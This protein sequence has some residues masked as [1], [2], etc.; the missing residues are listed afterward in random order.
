MTTDTV[1]DVAEIVPVHRDTDA[2][3][4]ALAAYDQL[5]GQLGRLAPEHW[6]AP[7]DCT[8]W[9]VAAI[10]GHL[11]GAARSN[12]STRE[13]LRQQLHGRRHASDHG[14]NALDACNALQVRDHAH[15]AP[16]ERV[17]QLRRL[18]P[19]AVAGRLRTPGLVRR[20]RV[21]LDQGG[22]TPPGSPDRLAMDR[23][24]DVVYTRDVWL[25]T[26]DVERATGVGVDRAVGPTRRLLE[27]VVAEW[28]ARHGRPFEL[29]LTGAGGGRFRQ[30]VGGP[31]IELDAVEFA[32]VLS[33]RA[34]G[35][36]LLAVRVVF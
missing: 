34:A 12:A 26:V 15:L 33:G 10:V 36:G 8:G 23:L 5:L 4:V 6:A 31:V 35:E 21:S 27:D 11:L 28:A 25:H 2:R 18:A 30:G 7:T 3:A 22:D 17:A 20:V 13:L 19:R 29:V 16:A 32:R 1:R 14:G 9:D 24:V